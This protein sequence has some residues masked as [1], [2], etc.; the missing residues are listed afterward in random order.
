MDL[1]ACHRGNVSVRTLQRYLCQAR[2]RMKKL[3]RKWSKAGMLPSVCAA[4]SAGPQRCRAKRARMAQSRKRLLLLAS[5][6]GI[7]LVLSATCR[8]A[9]SG[10]Q[11]FWGSL[12]PSLVTFYR[13]FPEFLGFGVFQEA[14]MHSA[15]STWVKRLPRRYMVQGFCF[16]SCS[17]DTGIP[18]KEP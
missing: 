8:T 13:F 18:N 3:R 14:G 16:L 9:F 6:A 2:I 1:R 10:L 7:P 15:W 5:M 11:P 17:W 12:R 4:R